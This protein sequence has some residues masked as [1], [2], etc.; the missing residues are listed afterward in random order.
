M[1]SL[2]VPIDFIRSHENCRAWVPQISESL[3]HVGCS[4]GVD[5]VSFQRA[6]IRIP[7][8]RLSRKVEYKVRTAS[9]DGFPDFSGIAQ[10]AEFVPKAIFKLKLREER[11]MG[12]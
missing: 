3:Q 8:Q 9:K 5:F 10:I 4:Q 1:P 6:K 2:L 12:S 7:N 11:G